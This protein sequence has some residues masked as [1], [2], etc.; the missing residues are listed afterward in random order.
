MILQPINLYKYYQDSVDMLRNVFKRLNLV[1]D[2]IA[3][4]KI[5]D[6]E[7]LR[8]LKEK[9]DVDN[10]DAISEEYMKNLVTI[11]YT[12]FR[13]NKVIKTFD[14]FE[15]MNAIFGRDG[16]FMDCSS[17]ESIKI[18]HTIDRIPGNC[19]RRCVKLNNVILPEGITLIGADS[20][21]GCSALKEIS[22]PN[23]VTHIYSG[24]F[25]GTNLEK[26]DLPESVTVIGSSVFNGLTSL[27]EV[28]IRGHIVIGDAAE[29]NLFKCWEN[30]TGLES[31]VMMSEM[32]M[33]FGF[34][35]MNGTTCKIYVPNTAV[36]TYKTAT[37]WNNLAGRIRPL[38][39]YKGV[40]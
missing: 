12:W 31:F 16:I 11:D 19:F 40:L 13:A 33:G 6:P 7:I 22:I 27:K 4:V 24:V 26:V 25:M 29:S 17:L 14:E 21:S 3:C 5:A 34:W 37:G 15:L 35:M 30:C 2:G 1:M 32:P 10:I 23:T 36:D 8:I 28:I 39:E 38:S 20:F 18:P 9:L